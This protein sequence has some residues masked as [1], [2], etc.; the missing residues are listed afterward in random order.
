MRRPLV[1]FGLGLIIPFAQAESPPVPRP[2]AQ[3]AILAG[4]SFWSLQASFDKTP[5]VISTVAGYCGGT[6]PDPTYEAVKSGRTKYR[7]AIEVTYDPMAISY[8]QLLTI[9]WRQIDPTQDSGQFTD[10]GPAYRTAIF[11]RNEQ[12]KKIAEVSKEKFQRSGKFDKT[13]VT[14]ILPATKFYPAEAYHQKYY[15]RH[16]AEF[17][18]FEEA[19]GRNSFRKKNWSDSH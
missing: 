4:G 12:E 18:A 8:E 16:P 15:E 6:E 14:E 7:E 5:G 9:Y 19:S 3:V 17:A 13:I 1:L 10:I 2:L 11:Y